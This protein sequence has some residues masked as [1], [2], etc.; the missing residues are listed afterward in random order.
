MSMEKNL[1]P[2]ASPASDT[3]VGV[4]S[5]ALFD[6]LVVF[7]KRKK[8]IISLPLAVAAAAAL[9]SMLTP[10][11]YRA[12]TTLLPPQQSQSGAAALIAKLGGA[13]MLDMG[14]AGLKSPGAVFVGMLKS[15][16]IADKLI[17]RFDLKTV[18]DLDLR[19]KQRRELKDNT[20][21]VAG[22][23]GLI[24][25]EVEDEDAK[26]SSQLA[27]AYGEELIIL[28]QVLA[29]TR[30]SQRRVF[31]ER[32]L[33]TAKNNLAMA[34]VKLKAVLERGG[35]ISVD[36]DSR[37]I[38]ETAAKLR[39]QI[40]AKEIELNAMR[41]FVTS[42]NQSFKQVQQELISLRGEADKLENGRLSAEPAPGGN[43]QAGLESIKLLRDVKYFQMLYEV[44]SKQYEVARLEEAQDTG[45]VQVLDA[46]I[47]PERRFKPKRAMIVAI[48]A[49]AGLVLALL[50]A[51]ALE[52][53]ARLIGLPGN[54]SRWSEFQRLLRAR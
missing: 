9:Y 22:K 1:Y 42:N 30:N 25:I 41:A 29:L 54:K 40:S 33:D 11:I 20:F 44:L 13:D 8:L 21:I 48:A 27:N 26:R 14:G 35:V 39:A 18:Y 47:A 52:H 3:T 36:T 4:E 31:Y 6:L 50:L 51:L 24:T 17:D 32:Q 23:D 37:A 2:S 16:T 10:P 53:G 34:E 7:A 38:V 12:S 49:G 45:L 43:K 19:D 28:T 5:S 15:R 46:A